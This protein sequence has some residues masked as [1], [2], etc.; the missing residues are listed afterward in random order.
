MNS[1]QTASRG[2]PSTRTSIRISSGR[3]PARKIRSYE[4]GLGG[5][6]WAA[7]RGQATVTATSARRGMRS[8]MGTSRKRE[9]GDRARS[10]SE[11]E[12]WPSLTLRALSPAPP[13]RSMVQQE[14]P[15]VEQHPEDVAE[16][17]VVAEC[18]GSAAAVE[19]AAEPCHLL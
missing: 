15:A 19:V 11:G 8:F 18:A 17:L 6:G 1:S 5:D 12:I 4:V 3:D 10:V 9:A 16:R 7:A 2:L 14:L 13:V